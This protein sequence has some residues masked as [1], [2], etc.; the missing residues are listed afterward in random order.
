MTF[1]A[2]TTPRVARTTKVV[3]VMAAAALALSACGGSS[4]DDKDEVTSLSVGSTPSLAGL[5]LQ[6]AIQEGSFDSRGLKVEAVENKSA[7]AAVPALLNGERQVAVM[8]TLTFMLAK[9]QGLPVRIIAGTGQQATNGDTDELSSAS[10][11]AASGSDI[12][13]AKDLV[14]KKV[15]VPAIKTQ[16][17]MNIRALV[18]AAGGDS[19]KIEFVEVPPAQMLDLLAKGT[20]DAATPNE[21]VASSAIA[22]GKFQLVHNTDAPGN[23]GVPSSVYAATETFVKENPETI[24]KF[25]EAIHESAEQVNGDRELAADVAGKQLGFKP[26]V[27]ENAFFVPFFTEPVKAEQLD[28]VSALAVK[29][30]ILASAPKSQDLLASTK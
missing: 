7:N 28:K 13:G 17:W 26:E 25:V 9:S 12:E 23:V 15:A 3:T 29:Y 18:D 21:P 22:S 6:T 27:L 19:D 4:D 14:G 1:L 24:D 8:D 2:S 5:G 11:V 20:V 16:T 10:I 30:E